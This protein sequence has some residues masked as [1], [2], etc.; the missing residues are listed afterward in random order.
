MSGR[1]RV[2][3]STDLQ[4]GDTRTVDADGVAIA[5]YRSDD[6]Q[7]FATQDSCSHEDWSLGE[8]SDIEGDKVICPL[9]MACFDLRTG[10]PLALPATEPLR[11][12]ALEVDDAGD[13][14]VLVSAEG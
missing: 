13:V 1:I 9:H 4:K 2:A 12:Y 6:G 10:E 14:Y 11:T 3:H 7:L 8:A 5:L